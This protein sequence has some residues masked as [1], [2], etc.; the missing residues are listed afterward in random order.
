MDDMANMLTT[1]NLMEGDCLSL[2]D[3]LE[4]NS[5]AACI[6]DPPYNYEF[7]GHKWDHSEIERRIAKVSNSSTLVKNIPY[8]SGLAGGVRNARWYKKNRDN[9]LEYQEWCF[10]WAQKVFRACKPGAFAA[11]FNSTR[12]AAH[13][14]ISLERAGFYARDIMVYRRK[15]GIPKGLNLSAQMAK[16]GRD[17]H[18]DWERWHSALRGEWEA[19]VLLQK[20]LINNYITTFDEYGIGLM[21]VINDDGSFQSNILEGYSER[22][23][24]TFNTH[25]TVKPLPLMEKLVKMLVPK[26]EDNLVLDPFA[27]SGTTLVAAQKLG[28]GYCGMEI[29]PEYCEIIRRRLSD[30]HSTLVDRKSASSIVKKAQNVETRDFFD[31]IE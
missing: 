8:G 20:P 31:E 7:V 3:K 19:I 6:T 11:V 10:L 15:S 27:G 24:D 9:I 5:I 26:G 25:C 17:D 12:T 13:V 2:L 30:H 23:V 18:A 16:K 22:N 14:Q 1:S 21:Q 28:R 4:E 29:V